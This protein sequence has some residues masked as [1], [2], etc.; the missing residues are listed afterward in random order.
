MVG[1]ETYGSIWRDAF[2]VCACGEEAAFAGEDGEDCGGVVV[3]VAE[4]G[5]GGFNEVAAKGV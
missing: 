5:D 4:R 1:R 3:E 2:H